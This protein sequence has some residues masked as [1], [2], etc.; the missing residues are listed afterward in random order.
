[1]EPNNPHRLT[2]DVVPSAY[3]VAIDTDLG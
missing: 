2:R 1:M 3:R